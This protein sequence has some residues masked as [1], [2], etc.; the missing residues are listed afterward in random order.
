MQP[1]L[2]VAAD[3]AT[4]N[5]VVEEMVEALRDYTE[6]WIDRF[7]HGLNHS[8]NWALVQ[9]IA[10]SDDQQLKDWLVGE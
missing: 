5:E 6:D 8:Q 10:L 3:A 4:V 2:P 9:L 7:L 1:V